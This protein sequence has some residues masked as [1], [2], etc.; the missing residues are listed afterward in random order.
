MF[1]SIVAG[2]SSVMMR[3]SLQATMPLTRKISIQSNVNVLTHFNSVALKLHFD[4]NKGINATRTMCEN[5][6]E[7]VGDGIL[8]IKRTFQP[9]LLR[10][11]RKHGFL[12]RKSTK[13]GIRVL[14][15][16]RFKKRVRL[17]P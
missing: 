2:P 12:A 7:L 1:R 9:S 14:N 10:K 13:D 8:M 15:R 3:K 4:I 16:R 6:M 5:A 17:C 11:K